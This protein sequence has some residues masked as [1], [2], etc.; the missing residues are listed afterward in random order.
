MEHIGISLG[1]NCHSAVYAVANGLRNI[2]KSGYKTCP[3]DIMVSN[4]K[5]LVE[6]LSD[7]FLYFYDEQYI[8][9]LKVNEH[10]YTIYNTKYNFAFNHESPGHDN[11][12]IS[13][14]W[15]GGINH[16]VDNNYRLLKERY[17][18][19]I[20]NFRSYLSDPN[21][22]ISFVITSWSK[23]QD[24]II[25]LKRAIETNYPNLKYEV[26]IL[27][28]PNGKEYYIKHLIY[29]NFTENDHELQR[30]TNSTNLSQ[31]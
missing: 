13:E 23:T 18:K 31:T 19:R 24:D 7:N 8:T 30:L 28:D 25:D 12:H 9:L 20:E 27:D 29:M 5:G 14:N 22:F 3:F 26:I 10:E 21:N 17:Q 4:Y 16:F 15:E 11:L 1:W 6:C 2:K